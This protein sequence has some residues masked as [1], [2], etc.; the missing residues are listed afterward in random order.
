MISQN[1]CV[2]VQLKLLKQYLG[3]PDKVSDNT[4]AATDE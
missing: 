3:Q 1:F 2:L 4:N